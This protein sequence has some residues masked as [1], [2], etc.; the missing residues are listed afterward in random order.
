[1]IEQL[2]KL[3]INEVNTKELQS[4]PSDFYEQIDEYLQDWIDLE[5]L[6]DIE[7]TIRD[8][9]LKFVKEAKHTLQ[10]IRMAKSQQSK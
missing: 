1:M 6:I 7:I 3:I 5:N 4:L 8:E 9:Y 2:S 10:N